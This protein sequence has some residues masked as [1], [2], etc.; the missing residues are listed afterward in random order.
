MIR[1]EDIEKPEITINDLEQRAGE[2][3]PVDQDLPESVIERGAEDQQA[4]D[5][6]DLN[7]RFAGM[8]RAENAV[9]HDEIE[10]LRQGGLIYEDE[11]LNLDPL[12][13]PPLGEGEVNV[14][15]IDPEDETQVMAAA[16]DAMGYGVESFGKPDSEFNYAEES[17]KS[18]ARGLFGLVAGWGV[19]ASEIDAFIKDGSA[20]V[21]AYLTALGVKDPDGDFEE[22][23]ESIRGPIVD[24]I[25]TE[26]EIVRQGFLMVDG[27]L[28]P[29][30]NKKL[31]WY[32][33]KLA[34]RYGPGGFVDLAGWV[35]SAPSMI[36]TLGA[37]G[38]AEAVAETG[39]Q[40]SALAYGMI[41]SAMMAAGFRVLNAT[42][43]K[44]KQAFSDLLL[45]TT[46]DKSGNIVVSSLA[47]RSINALYG[48]GAAAFAFGAGGVMTDA[49]RNYV[50]QVA[51]EGIYGAS[52]Q[53]SFED[54]LDNVA[55]HA[56]FGAAFGMMPL[57][58]ARSQYRNWLKTH[59]HAVDI[60]IQRLRK[61]QGFRNLSPEEQMRAIAR[62]RIEMLQQGSVPAAARIAALA[63]EARNA[64]T[65]TNSALVA[66][67]NRLAEQIRNKH[68]LNQD[69]RIEE[70]QLR[71]FDRE[72]RR[73]KIDTSAKPE[74]RAKTEAEVTSPEVPKPVAE[75]PAP[76]APG[77]PPPEPVIGRPATL[78]TDPVAPP[79]PTNNQARVRELDKSLNGNDVKGLKDLPAAEPLPTVGA[80]FTRSAYK[81]AEK[82]YNK[83]IA[84]AQKQDLHP[85]IAEQIEAVLGKGA[86]TS[87]VSTANVKELERARDFLKQLPGD[88][89]RRIGLD[90]LE[91]EVARNTRAN[92]FQ[93]KGKKDEEL[94]ALFQELQ[95][96]NR[97]LDDALRLQ[98]DL[99]TARTTRDKRLQ[100]KA[101][102]KTKKQAEG[103]QYKQEGNQ[104][105]PGP[106]VGRRNSED[107][108]VLGP[109]VRE[110]GGPNGTLHTFT[111]DMVRDTARAQ[112]TLREVDQVIEQAFLNVGVR[113]NAQRNAIGASSKPGQIVA[114]VPLRGHAKGKRKGQVGGEVEFMISELE[115]VHTYMLLHDPSTLGRIA[116]GQP[117]SFVRPA[118]N[119]GS[120]SVATMVLTADDVSNIFRLMKARSNR[121]GEPDLIALADELMVVHSRNGPMRGVQDRS[122]QRLYLDDLGLTYVPRRV[123]REKGATD[124]F[125]SN[126]SVIQSVEKGAPTNVDARVFNARD[127]GVI[128]APIRVG[129]A[130]DELRAAAAGQVVTELNPY[131]VFI[132]RQL[133]A[134]RPIHTALQRSPHA[135]LPEHI[136]NAFAYDVATMLRRRIG[137]PNLFDTFQQVAR[138][139]AYYGYLAYKGSTALLQSTS[140][141]QMYGSGY[142]RIPTRYKNPVRGKIGLPDAVMAFGPSQRAAYA[143]IM[144]VGD[145]ALKNR[146]QASIDETVMGGMQ[147][148]RM[149]VRGRSRGLL[150][151]I[152]D[153]GQMPMSHMDRT[154]IIAGFQ[155]T[156]RWV[157]DDFMTLARSGNGKMPKASSRSATGFDEMPQFEAL[158]RDMRARGLMTPEG[159]LTKAGKKEIKNHPAFQRVVGER[160]RIAWTE[161]Q[162]TNTGLS[163]TAWQ[164]RTRI[165][166]GNLFAIVEPFQGWVSKAYSDLR[167]GNK[168]GVLQ[169]IIYGQVIREM[170]TQFYGR[171]M[172]ARPE[173]ELDLESAGGR[174]LVGAASDVGGIATP[175][176]VDIFARQGARSASLGLVE[177]SGLVY[178]DEIPEF[179]QF[180]TPSTKLAREL[181]DLSQLDD[182]ADPTTKEGARETVLMASLLTRVFGGP[183]WR[184]QFKVIIALNALQNRAFPKE[185]SGT[186]TGPTMGDLQ[187]EIRQIQDGDVDD[188]LEEFYGLPEGSL[189]DGDIGN[190]IDQSFQD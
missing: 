22:T 174:M 170:F 157:L 130:A 32:D 80:D 159:V 124:N 50:D 65:M 118:R 66:N 21:V 190:L 110:V 43:P 103:S 107:G 138:E 72:I 3:M 23:M 41:H 106:T 26:R 18:F 184:E 180:Q 173:E 94:P 102:K 55:S 141:H 28:A 175:P 90:R 155:S 75:S 14:E 87:R 44:A 109:R 101:D 77:T 30:P 148:S 73:R 81:A 85:E 1:I 45:G 162:P 84:R 91:A 97:T 40:R 42:G 60:Q 59:N 126:T 133:N 47:R 12:P 76:P 61:S 35:F 117:I 16:A 8:E 15:G 17:T 152:S 105:R 187:D 111:Q 56:G 96:A 71:H 129:N 62:V 125:T 120:Q 165:G 171:V 149:A 156:E 169:A 99:V 167:S 178:P 34:V 100:T 186:V 48:P 119:T 104:T 36:A 153:L 150:H 158:V 29:D 168:K 136:Q 189:K 38:Y 128:T 93:S 67:R 51:L 181:Y 74:P 63:T 52:I 185:K 33:P 78:T 98:D 27:V 10:I 139:F 188:L 64:T 13:I 146:L 4:V 39:D 183:Q 115:L 6:N 89:Q 9:E 92:R 24:K 112:G 166:K 135:T 108:R 37:N 20:T 58:G 182:V 132:Q 57:V 179:K 2:M 131:A 147:Q 142:G 83:L 163:M 54:S 68:R 140:Y 82:E 145:P 11:P 151:R 46:V 154:T 144:A 31:D 25:E 79:R 121:V 49:A 5:T 19:V 177:N 176:I 113:T 86:V 134:G 70:V 7:Q 69:S 161:T 127:P 53:K 114:N 88:A 143:R 122:G 172:D 123:V 160:Y 164:T 116:A 137:D 95:R